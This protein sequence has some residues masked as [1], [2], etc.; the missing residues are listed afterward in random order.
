M[1]DTFNITRF[2]WFLKKTLLERPA[3]LIGLIILSMAL[4]LLVYA[5]AKFT[6]GFEVAQMATFLTGLIGGGCF[7]ASL[8]Y[9]YFSTNASG[10]SFLTLPA[11]ANLQNWEFGLALLRSRWPKVIASDGSGTLE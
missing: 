10:A 11:S 8:V 1:N 6:S 2:G 5:F 3:Q 4:S 7:L 9:G